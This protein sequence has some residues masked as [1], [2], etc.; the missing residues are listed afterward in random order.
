MSFNYMVMYIYAC[1]FSHTLTNKSG[2]VFYWAVVPFPRQSWYLVLVAYPAWTFT[3]PSACGF[4]SMK[5]L[6][7]LYACSPLDTD[8][9][10]MLHSSI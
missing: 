1:M 8:S 10:A 7:L 4:S 2:S 9:F 3:L 5:E 6:W